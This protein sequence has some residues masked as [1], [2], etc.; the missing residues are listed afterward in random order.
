MVL[1]S[2]SGLKHLHEIT[3]QNYSTY[4][5][6]KQ[7]QMNGFPLVQ[8]DITGLLHITSKSI[9]NYIIAPLFFGHSSTILRIHNDKC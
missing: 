7:F 9:T 6:R 5:S 2:V 8:T 1:I 4:F 3:V